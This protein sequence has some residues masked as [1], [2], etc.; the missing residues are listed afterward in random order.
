MLLTVRASFLLVGKSSIG[1]ERQEKEFLEI[2][3]QQL[4]VRE[5]IVYKI[6]VQEMKIQKLQNLS[7]RDF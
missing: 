2:R 4:K 7:N 3:L 1:F 6:E 5:I